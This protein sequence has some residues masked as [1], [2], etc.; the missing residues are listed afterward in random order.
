MAAK[1]GFYT[2]LGVLPSEFLFGTLFDMFGRKKFICAGMC[3]CGITMIVITQFSEVYPWLV[4]FI[5][6][7]G[8]SLIPAIISPLQVDYLLPQSMGASGAW[9]SIFSLLGSTAGTSGALIILKAFNINTVFVCYGIFTIL[10]GLFLCISIKE[11][12]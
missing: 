10:V 3:I 12:F 2:D 7:L 1:L 5:V 6:T 11:K 9:I 4:V 8:I